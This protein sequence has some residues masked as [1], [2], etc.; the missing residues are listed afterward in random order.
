MLGMKTS[1]FQPFMVRYYEVDAG[2]RLALEHLC[3][4]MQQI[5]GQHAEGVR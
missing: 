5:A 3:N 2:G 4:Y 1:L